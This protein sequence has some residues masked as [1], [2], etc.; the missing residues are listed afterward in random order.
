MSFSNKWAPTASSALVKLMDEG[1]GRR[2]PVVFDFDNTI[3]C[4]DIR[5]A[6]FAVLVRD[7]VL[8]PEQIPAT[9]SPSFHSAAGQEVTVT[10]GPDLTAYYETFLD[11]TAHGK[12]DPTPYA[13]SYAWVVEI[14]AGLTPLQIV[15]A[16]QRVY[17]MSRPGHLEAIEVTPGSTAYPA[18]FFY[19]EM[20]EFI[21][22]LLR[23]EFEVWI[24]SASNVWSVRWMVLS[25]LNPRLR[26]LG[27]PD[28]I[29]ERR[30]LAAPV[31]AS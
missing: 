31:P 9:I 15:Q 10:S 27:A 23:K 3:V 20:V 6:T 2:L 4:G 18:P 28:G 11:P 16:T 24:V 5:E 21:S 30:G 13:N 29:D 7:G 26:A 1:A 12:A 14:M 8:E 17:S 25:A 22:E 19:E